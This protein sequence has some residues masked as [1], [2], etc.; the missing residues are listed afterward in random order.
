MSSDSKGP[1]FVRPLEESED[2]HRWALDAFVDAYSTFP[3]DAEEIV[4]FVERQERLGTIEKQIL[5]DVIR[6][7]Y[8]WSKEQ[9][10]QGGDQ[11]FESLEVRLIPA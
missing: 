6:E 1:R 3:E 7:L 11:G 10:S 5:Y 2:F 9:T 8:A 4:A